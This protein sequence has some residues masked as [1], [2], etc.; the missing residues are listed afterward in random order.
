MCEQWINLPAYPI[1]SAFSLSVFLP[2]PESL[3]FEWPRGLCH[4][5]HTDDPHTTAWSDHPQISPGT[6]ERAL[7]ASVCLWGS[8]LVSG[9]SC[10]STW[11][12]QGLLWMHRLSQV[13]TPGG[14][15][16]VAL[17]LRLILVIVTFSRSSQGESP[18]T[19]AFA[20]DTTT[21]PV[22][23]RKLSEVNLLA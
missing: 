3:G 19:R 16:F 10:R 7:R 15:V 21:F 17:E 2:S 13:L 18:V 20:A 5:R 8:P 23:N 12:R 1:S 14:F 11:K 6:E 22:R 4:C 9:N